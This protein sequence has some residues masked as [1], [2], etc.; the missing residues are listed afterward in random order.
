MQIPNPY[1]NLPASFDLYFIQ[2]NE[3]FAG[4][5]LSKL[6]PDLSCVIPNTWFKIQFTQT[7]SSVLSFWMKHVL[8][9][10]FSSLATYTNQTAPPI[11][12]KCVWLPFALQTWHAIQLKETFP[13]YFHVNSTEWEKCFTPGKRKEE[14][15]SRRRG[16]QAWIQDST[17][18]NH[19][20]GPRILVLPHDEYAYCIPIPVPTLVHQGKGTQ[21]PR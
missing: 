8:P 12:Q 11:R 7:F 6:C 19:L 4:E 20:T 9:V 16:T 15:K 3:N 21:Y 1:L 2:K 17:S 14:R 10:A 18:I 5:V 13:F